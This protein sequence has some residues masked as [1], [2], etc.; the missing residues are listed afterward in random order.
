M[1]PDDLKIREE[2]KAKFRKIIKFTQLTL[3]PLHA[4]INFVAEQWQ[5]DKTSQFWSRAAIRCLCASIEATLFSFRKM[6]EQLAVVSGIQ[7][8]QE[9]AEILSGKRIIERNGVKIAR[10]KYLPFSDAVKESFRLFA[11][12]VGI[13]VKIDYASGGYSDL[14]NAFEIRNRLMHPKTP[15][16]VQVTVEEIKTTDRGT[17]WFNKT[18]NDV[19][20]QC[21]ANVRE[22]IA[23]RNA[24]SKSR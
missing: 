14:C 20:N 18:Y 8:S 19:L 23:I 1:K 2:K 5:K 13:T 15:F 11:K 4:D 17:T 12:S 24:N 7:F 10:P 22:N 16:D 21:R 3:R 6:A 9:E